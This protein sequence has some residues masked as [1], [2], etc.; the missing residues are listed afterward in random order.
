M[1]TTTFTLP[2]SFVEQYSAD[3]YRC[4]SCNY[5]VEAV[6]AERGIKHVCATLEH[7]SPAPGYSGRGFIDIARALYEGRPLATDAVAERVFTCTGCGNCETLC[8]IGLHPAAI[9]QSLREALAVA[10]RLPGPVD[11]ALRAV[12]DRGERRREAAFKR[13]PV[14]GGTTLSVFAGCSASDEARA[15][16]GWL[17]EAG[18]E[19]DWRGGPERCCGAVLD[20]L[21]DA[22]RG[23]A[24]A[25][26]AAADLAQD[27]PTV[28]LGY[29]CLASLGVAAAEALSLPA[30]LIARIDA[31]QITLHARAGSA[32]RDVFLFES[33]RLKPRPGVPAP[34][35]ERSV[36][37]LLERLGMRVLNDGYPNAHALCCGAGAALPA[38]Q[39]EA[40]LSMAR[41][42]VAGLAGAPVVALDP[43]C[44]T[45]VKAASPDTRVTGLVE[46]LAR[47]FELRAG[48]A[49]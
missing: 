15:L 10:E 40:A 48:D 35:D 45:H 21:G 32:A 14:A 25:A 24:W 47:T 1:S 31:G 23:R 18:I 16:A 11:R 30:W 27:D 12:L 2:A 49:A 46:F 6:W 17:A 36:R 8:P 34:P 3:L 22:R 39:P 33:C 44:A 41:G 5:C 7:H 28:V 19:V 38:M 20:D 9:G 42:R 43:R 13:A 29:E 37:V 4:A 26:A